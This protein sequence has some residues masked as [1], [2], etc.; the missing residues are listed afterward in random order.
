MTLKSRLGC[1]LSVAIDGLIFTSHMFFFFISSYLV[2]LETDFDPE[3]RVGCRLS[4]AIDGLIFTSHMLL[5]SYLVALETNFDPEDRVG[6]EL[7]LIVYI[8]LPCRLGDKL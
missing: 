8:D 6:G 3:E 4:V 7:P 5:P 2:T 1:R